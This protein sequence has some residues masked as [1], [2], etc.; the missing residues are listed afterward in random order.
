VFRSAFPEVLKATAELGAAEGHDG[1]GTVNGPVHSGAFAE[2][3][4]TLGSIFFVPVLSIPPEA[5]PDI[6]TTLV[7]RDR[8]PSKHGDTLAGFRPSG[9]SALEN[10]ACGRTGRPAH[11]IQSPLPLFLF[12]P[13]K[14]QKWLPEGQRFRNEDC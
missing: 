1:V 2:L 8:P 11:K 10:S 7:S 4:L 9:I 3:F 5:A 6:A 12:A 14:L 13:S